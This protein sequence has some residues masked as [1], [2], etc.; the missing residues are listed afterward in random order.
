MACWDSAIS[1]LG[2]INNT[3][4]TGLY[5]LWQRHAPRQWRQLNRG[6]LY[7]IQIIT[8]LILLVITISVIFYLELNNLP[9]DIDTIA[10]ARVVNKVHAFRSDAFRTVSEAQGLDIMRLYDVFVC[11]DNPNIQAVLNDDYCDCADG[12]DEPMG[13]ACSHILAASHRFNCGDSEEGKLI[14]VSRI[15]DGVCDCLNGADEWLKGPDYCLKN[16]HSRTA[17]SQISTR[18]SGLRSDKKHNIRQ[19]LL[20]NITRIRLSS[21]NI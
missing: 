6:D 1:K 5:T 16:I 2:I 19:N 9:S 7:I 17:D 21:L 14:Y 4:C 8:M 3:I 12:L 15:N 13:N 20:G 11:K 18:R 10:R